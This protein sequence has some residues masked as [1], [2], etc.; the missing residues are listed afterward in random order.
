MNLYGNLF[1]DLSSE[2]VT[3]FYTLWHKCL[4]KLLDLPYT[5]HSRY[6]PLI[7]ND[8]PVE[9]QLFRRVNNFMCNMS[10]ST[11]LCVKLCTKLVLNG[12][13][14]NISKTLNHII[15]HTNVSMKV[16]YNTNCQLLKAVRDHNTSNEEDLKHVGNIKDLL[17]M[18]VFK[19]GFTAGEIDAMLNFVCTT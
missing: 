16:M 2:K 6:I 5:T 8:V 10:A 11:N 3:S 15:Y 14:S 1:W 4:R 13:C 9:T 19:N 12:S 17:S 7:V 18:R